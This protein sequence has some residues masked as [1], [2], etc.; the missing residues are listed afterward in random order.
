MAYQ[1]SHGYGYLSWEWTMQEPIRSPIYQ[2]YLKLGYSVCQ[3][4]N[5]NA[6][7]TEIAPKVMQLFLSLL[8]D[9]YLLKTV[10]YYVRSVSYLVCLC[11]LTNW[12][13]FSMLNRI[14]INSAE[15]CL[16][17]IAFYYWTTRKEHAMNDYMSRLIV[18]LNFSLRPTSLFLWVVI[19]P[20][21]LLTKKEGKMKFIFKNALQLIA[22]GLFSFLVGS[23]WYNKWIWIDYNFFK[24][25]VFSIVV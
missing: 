25:K 11:L 18:I 23:L 16:G 19:W 21:E 22:I 3:L 6:Y 10:T 13:Y 4:T 15:T 12:Y 20:Y 14:Y 9:W 24:V 8:C 7:L 2:L 1:L 17:L 5:C